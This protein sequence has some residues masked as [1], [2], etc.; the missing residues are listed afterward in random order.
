MSRLPY[1][2]WKFCARL[3]DLLTLFIQLIENV[4]LSFET[5][6]VKTENPWEKTILTI[7]C[8]K[9]VDPFQG[10]LLQLSQNG[11]KRWINCERNS[12]LHWGNRF[13]GWIWQSHWDLHLNSLPLANNLQQFRETND[14]LFTDRMCVEPSWTA[15]LHKVN[16]CCTFSLMLFLSLQIYELAKRL[17]ENRKIFRFVRYYKD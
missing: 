5:E 7:V 11:I 4:Y 9:S 14:L 1:G 8:R 6:K 15:D 12:Y 16:N 3:V 2:F 13:M 10:A 17:T